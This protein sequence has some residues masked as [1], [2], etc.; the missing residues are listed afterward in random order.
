MIRI[1][2]EIPLETAARVQEGMAQRLR[3]TGRRVPMMTFIGEMIA[4]GVDSLLVKDL[5]KP[6]PKPKTASV[7]TNSDLPRP[8]A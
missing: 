2:I 8:A 1:Q 5:K 3:E 4:R 7:V 6:P